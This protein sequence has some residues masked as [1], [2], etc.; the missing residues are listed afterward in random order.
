MYFG[1]DW[2]EVSNG[3]EEGDKFVLF[4]SSPFT[5]YCLTGREAIY[6]RR[7]GRD[8]FSKLTSMN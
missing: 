5:W 6:V 2:E 4:R 3:L 7:D 8:I 1:E